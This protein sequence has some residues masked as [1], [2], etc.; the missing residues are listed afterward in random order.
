MTQVNFF[1]F[2]FTAESG[3]VAS[4]EPLDLDVPVPD[5]NSTIQVA[6]FVEHHFINKA[7][8]PDYLS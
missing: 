2:Y 5:I 4:D 8:R 1:S 7:T 6:D 3:S